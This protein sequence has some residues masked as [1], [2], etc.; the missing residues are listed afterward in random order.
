[1]I[2]EDRRNMNTK[3]KLYTQVSKKYDRIIKVKD[4]VFGIMHMNITI[5]IHVHNTNIYTNSHICTQKLDSL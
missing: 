3:S 2:T 4:Y 1:M 5:H